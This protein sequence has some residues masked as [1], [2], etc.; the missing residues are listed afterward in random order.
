MK[1]NPEELKLIYV[2][3]AGYN[4]KNEG[5][6]E[7]VFSKEPETIDYEN[8]CW[9]ATP[10]CDNALPP[11]EGFYDE[12]YELRTDK[13]DLFCLHEAVDRPYLHGYYNIHCLAYEDPDSERAPTDEDYDDYDNMF[14]SG[15]QESNKHDDGK[16]LVF[17]YRMTLQDV[18]DLLYE[19]DIILKGKQFT[20]ATNIS[21]V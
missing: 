19:K 18:E 20:T 13:F 15:Y 7:F 5:L 6:Y 8:W 2:H 21:I 16:I 1:H 9:D 12:S 10:A 14:N 17:H 11:T 4:T 3:K